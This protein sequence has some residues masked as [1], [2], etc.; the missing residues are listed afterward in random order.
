MFQISYKRGGRH[1]HLRCRAAKFL[2]CNIAGNA[3]TAFDIF[4]RQ[5]AEA[6]PET[7]AIS[8]AFGKVIAGQEADTLFLCPQKNVVR[9]ERSGKLYPDVQ[10]AVR[11]SEPCAGRKKAAT[12]S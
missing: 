2:V 4:W 3:N 5:A 12:G 9:V 1:K 7:T 6:Q 8:A 11:T 10:A